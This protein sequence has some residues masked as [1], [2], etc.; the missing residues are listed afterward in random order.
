MSEIEPNLD[1]F[2]AAIQLACQSQ[3]AGRIVKGRQRVLAFPRAWVLEQ[4]EQRAIQSLDLS[5][6]WEY[7][8]LLELAEMLDADLVQRFVA[9][10]VDSKDPDVREAAEDF[11]K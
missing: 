1:T 4:I 8:R 10:G 5:D 7:R 2:R 11:R 3:N 9:I 6:E